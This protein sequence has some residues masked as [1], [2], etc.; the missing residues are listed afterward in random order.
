MI[1]AKKEDFQLVKDM[2][3]RRR[4]SLFPLITI[5]KKLKKDRV[6]AMEQYLG[7]ISSALRRGSFAMPFRDI[8]RRFLISYCP[9]STSSWNCRSRP[10]CL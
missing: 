10:K 1:R 7:I 3:T 2:G 5:F 6:Q 9:L 8:T 4:G